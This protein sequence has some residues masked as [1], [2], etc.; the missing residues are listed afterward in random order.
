MPAPASASLEPASFGPSDSLYPETAHT[1][2]PAIG[3]VHEPHVLPDPGT[4]E[5]GIDADKLVPIEQAP[6]QQDLVTIEETVSLPEEEVAW[7]ALEPMPNADFIVPHPSLNETV[8]V[9]PARLESPPDDAVELTS[10]PVTPTLEKA[11]SR[12]PDGLGVDVLVAP[13]ENTEDP[14]TVLNPPMMEAVQ[15]PLAEEHRLGDP[16]QA[17][18]TGLEEPDGADGETTTVED[19]LESP[20]PSLDHVV[21]QPLIVLPST[22]I[23]FNS[24][25]IR[26]SATD[27]DTEP[28]APSIEHL[29]LEMTEFTYFDAKASQR[30]D[31]PPGVAASSLSSEMAHDTFLAMMILR[32]NQKL[33]ASETTPI[34][35]LK[36]SEGLAESR[37]NLKS[38]STKPSPRFAQAVTR[39]QSIR[40]VACDAF[41]GALANRT[42]AIGDWMRHDRTETKTVEVVMNL[43]DS[44]TTT[45]AAG[46]AK[47]DPADEKA[48]EASPQASAGVV[49][50]A[51]L[52]M[53]ER[54]QLI[55]VRSHLVRQRLKRTTD[56][57]V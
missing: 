21:S 44:V 18:H 35:T 15:P 2:A 27:E 47:Q 42:R 13:L 14:A 17:L 3:P 57:T 43:D 28:V 32:P 49:V 52:L 34:E 45:E 56:A 22:S 24:E 10:D 50:V 23:E 11:P 31:D 46:S 37:P 9:G 33:A 12:E 1:E 25:K 20:E 54:F 5:H 16:I 38:G 26:F 39:L 41:F 51:A 19:N 30:T 8:L 36:S 29:R 53:G 4:D 7:E 55:Q 40:P 48:S 6:I